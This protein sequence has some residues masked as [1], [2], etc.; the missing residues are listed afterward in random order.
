MITAL[1]SKPSINFVIFNFQPARLSAI[2]RI[3]GIVFRR[4][5]PPVNGT[6]NLRIS[7]YIHA[8]PRAA[9]TPYF[10]IVGKKY[11]VLYSRY[12]YLSTLRPR[13]PVSRKP[14]IITIWASGSPATDNQISSACVRVCPYRSRATRKSG[15]LCVPCG[16]IPVHAVARIPCVI[17]RPYALLLS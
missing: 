13:Y 2:R 1:T 7:G 10:I 16:R 9:Q 12:P 17:Y 5:R 11:R 4:P 6:F 15:K 14:D 3:R 8:G